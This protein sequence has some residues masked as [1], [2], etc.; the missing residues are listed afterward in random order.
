MPKESFILNDFSGGINSKV[1]PRDIQGNYVDSV[2]ASIEGRDA[3]KGQLV[4]CVNAEVY[5]NGSIRV[6]GGPNATDL[7]SGIYGSTSNT[8]ITPGMGFFSYPT[9]YGSNM[10]RS[11]DF[12]GVATSYWVF[13]NNH[14][15]E[16]YTFPSVGEYAE[17]GEGDG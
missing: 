11:L 4:E 10:I 2:D 6:G 3:K 17:V 1:N 14:G 13:T 8:A 12:G 16:T 9:D 15:A 5:I 7:Y